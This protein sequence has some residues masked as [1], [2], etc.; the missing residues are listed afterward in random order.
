MDSN[1]ATDSTCLN[2][3]GLRTHR[4]ASS[5]LLRNLVFT[6]QPSWNTDTG[7]EHRIF[8]EGVGRAYSCRLAW[9]HET[10]FDLHESRSYEFLS[11]AKCVWAN[12]PRS[13]AKHLCLHSPWHEQVLLS[14][15]VASMWIL[16][17]QA[18]WLCPGCKFKQWV[19]QHVYQRSVWTH[20][21]LAPLASLQ[22]NNFRPSKLF[23][24]LRHC[25]C[26]Y[27][28]KTNCCWGTQRTGMSK[29]W[30]KL[31]LTGVW[32]DDSWLMLS[33]QVVHVDIY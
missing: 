33:A 3:H 32:E 30:C 23:P 12:Q 14:S 16:W 17:M 29:D 6:L 28:V 8:L 15:C 11:F 26:P 19:T 1:N 25:C 7:C 21:D 20:K 22:L 9:P 5:F 18:C 13:Q 27:A 4:I 2:E 31:R 10:I 24:A